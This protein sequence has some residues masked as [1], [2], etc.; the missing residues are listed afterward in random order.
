MKLHDS[1]ADV[2]AVD[3][4]TDRLA[5]YLLFLHLDLSH[6]NEDRQ[7]AFW[8]ELTAWLSARGLYLG[9]DPSAAAVYA[10]RRATR[11]PSP[12]WRAV[13]RKL[14]ATGAPLC[15]W[16]E[17]SGAAR[18]APAELGSPGGRTRRASST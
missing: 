14:D 2:A 7:D 17:G 8:T 12:I 1:T 18:A 3:G 11:S 6:W 4:R 9:G 5:G 15:N 16:R 13:R 10:P